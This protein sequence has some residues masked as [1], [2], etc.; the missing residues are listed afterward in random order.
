M[1]RTNQLGCEFVTTIPEKLEDAVLYVSMEYATVVHKCCCGCDHEVVTP[2]S[3]TDWNLSYDGENISLYPSIGNWSFK[4]KSHYWIKRNAVHWAGKMTDE[5]VTAVR[6]R[7]L[8]TK[9][10]YYTQI[11]TATETNVITQGRETR[12][13]RLVQHVRSLLGR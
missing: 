10:A 8:E 7:D 11:E 4:C 9:S 13:Q 3:P 5:Q 2:L 12:W 6:T 1:T